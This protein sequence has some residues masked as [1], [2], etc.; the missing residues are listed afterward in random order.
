VTSG[1]VRPQVNQKPKVVSIDPVLTVTRES[2]VAGVLEHG[3]AVGDFEVLADRS[4]RPVVP[5]PGEVNHTWVRVLMG[6][7]LIATGRDL[8]D[9]VAAAMPQRLADLIRDFVE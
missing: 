4:V 3:I 2:R 7:L 1:P 8:D 5:Q 9:P 6:E